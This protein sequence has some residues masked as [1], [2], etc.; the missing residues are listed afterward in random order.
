MIY[1]LIAITLVFLMINFLLAGRDYMHPA[2]V[3]HGMF[4]IYELVCVL[5]EEAYAVKLHL[6]STVVLSMGFFAKTLANLISYDRRK[7]KQLFI[8]KL[9]EIKIPKLYI[10]ALL[11]MQTVSIVYFYKYLGDLANAYGLKNLTLSE[12]IKLYDTM[13]KFWRDEYNA[14]S[15][16]IP[17]AYRITNPICAGAE[18]IVIYIMVNNFLVNKK[19]D[20]LGVASFG[21][22]CV[23]IVI[24]GSRSPLLRIF[25]FVFLLFYMLN[26]RSGRIRKGDTKFFGKLIMAAA[27][28]I[29]LMFLSLI[30]MGRTERFTGIADNLFVYLGAPIVNL[31]NFI[32][33]Y[34]VKL[35]GAISKRALFGAQS[36]KG[37]YQYIDKLFKVDA[38]SDIT[39]IELFVFSDNGRE[40]GNVYTMFYK[41]IYDFGFLGV[42]PLTFIMG[43]F[44]CETYRKIKCEPK[45][46]RII[47]LRLLVYA[48]LFNDIVMSA[49]SNRFYETIFDAVFIKFFIVVWGLDVFLLE[50]MNKIKVIVKG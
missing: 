32:E 43:T 1:I 41:I 20:I 11:I 47:D 37:L 21:L 15:V 22:M 7:K 39:D 44:C 27:G 16:P 46:D 4:L 14:L 18:Y 42:L 24:N 23:R 33:G 6:G 38:F 35:L 34:N 28:F 30:V 25:T 50:P 9:R 36:F 17:M 13:T 40:I 10:L 8:E 5:G 2:V 26:L 49:F 48:Y 31:D 45:T 29:V 19:I 12:S 3:F